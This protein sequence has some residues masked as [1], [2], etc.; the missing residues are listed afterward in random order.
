MTRVRLGV[1]GLG[2][3]GSE[4]L[5]VAAAHP[6]YDVRVAVDLDPAARARA[7]D[8]HPGLVVTGSVGEVFSADLDAV[9]VATPPRT[10]ADLSLRALEAGLA[11]FC[12]KPLAIDLDEGEAMAKAAVAAEAATGVNFAL[13]D[14]AAV[15]EVERALRSGELGDPRSVEIRLAF[16]QWPRAFQADAL[17]LDRREQGGFLREVF[18]HFAYLTDRLLGELTPVWRDVRRPADPDG[19]EVAATAVFEVGG[20]PVRL[21]AEAG[22]A[23]P[24][25]YEWTLHGTDRSYRLTDWGD[26][27]ISTG[28]AWQPVEVTGERGSEH[29]RLTAFAAAVRREPAPNLATF[30]DALRVQRVV[31]GLFGSAERRE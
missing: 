17:W 22:S 27:A 20:V 1:V 2:A 7:A 10:H 6:E 15:L 12:E 31:E 30:A 8:A 16:P 13:S 14:R 24:E 29:T 23:R 19:A 21:W 3:M 28:D 26:L 9:Y 4:L 5:A 18:S 25:T 11:V